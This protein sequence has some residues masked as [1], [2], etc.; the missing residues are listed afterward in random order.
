MKG[1]AAKKRKPDAMPKSEIDRVLEHR[2][3][4]ETQVIPLQQP[5]KCRGRPLIFK[6]VVSTPIST[7]DNKSTFKGNMKHRNN[8]HNEDDADAKEKDIFCVGDEN[9][10]VIPHKIKSESVSSSEKLV[11][12]FNHYMLE[13]HK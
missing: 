4:E 5:S 9:A 10:P 3:R 6:D 7:T 2:S 12:F 8:Y 1:P 13:F 11:S